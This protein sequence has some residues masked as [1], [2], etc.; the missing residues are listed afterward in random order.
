MNSGGGRM[1]TSLLRIVK[2]W[3][4][5]TYREVPWNTVV[6]STG[7]IVYFLTPIDLIPDVIPVLGLIDDIPTV[8]QLMDRFIGEAVATIDTRLKSLR[9][10]AR[11]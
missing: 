7:A 2:N 6:L 8:Q 10:G 3:R 4:A 9:T 5:G 11:L 1:V